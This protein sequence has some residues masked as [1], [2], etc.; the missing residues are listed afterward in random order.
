MTMQSIIAEMAAISRAR[1]Q[2]DMTPEEIAKEKAKRTADQVAWKAG[3]PEREARHA[4]EVNE[5]RRQSW[6]RTPRYDVPGGTGRPHRLLG[7]LANGFEADGGRVI[8]VLPSDD[9]GDYVWGRSACGKRP[10]GRSQGWVSVERAAT[11]PRCLSKATLTA[12]SGEP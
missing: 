12:P 2:E 8:H 1:R 6:L 4:A 10:G 5:E 3:E 11:C 7:R 9:A